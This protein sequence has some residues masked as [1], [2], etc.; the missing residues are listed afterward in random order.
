MNF[1]EGGIEEI[2][3]CYLQVAKEAVTHCEVLQ[4]LGLLV[5][6]SKKTRQNLLVIPYYKLHKNEK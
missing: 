4:R 1:G 3:Q 6:E 2:S 5:N